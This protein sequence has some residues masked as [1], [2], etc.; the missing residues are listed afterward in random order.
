MLLHDDW[1]LLPYTHELL[2]F[3]VSDG[4][5]SVENLPSDSIRRWE[6]NFSVSCQYWI[7]MHNTTGGKIHMNKFVQQ[8]QKF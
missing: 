6:K 8:G 5:S 2:K 1:S 7:A 3:K 4:D